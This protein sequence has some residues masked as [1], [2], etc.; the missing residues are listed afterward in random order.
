M[1]DPDPSV[2]AEVARIESGAG[3]R[4]GAW[5]SDTGWWWAT[6]NQALTSGEL[7]AGCEQHV[8]ASSSDELLVLIQEQ[9]ALALELGIAD[10]K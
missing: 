5:K 2:A 9:N 4:W 1:T 10:P 7:S 8:H 6:R 3:G